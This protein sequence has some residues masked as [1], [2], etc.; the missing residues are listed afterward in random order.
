M[1][2]IPALIFKDDDGN[3]AYIYQDSSCKLTLDL[4]NYLGTALGS[5]SISAVTLTLIDRTS[6]TIMV[7]S[8]GSSPLSIEDMDVLSGLGADG[9]MTWY[10]EGE[11]NPIVSTDDKIKVET[12]LAIF[13]FSGTYAGQTVTLTIPIKQYITNV[14]KV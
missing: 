12:H 10:L 8:A 5:A 1:A 3:D 9:T 11:S 2:D 7:Q 6:G 4:K 13:T 14:E